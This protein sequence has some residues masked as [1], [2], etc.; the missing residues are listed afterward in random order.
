M[1]QTPEGEEAPG[2]AQ[3][4]VSLR[5]ATEASARLCA[6][7]WLPVPFVG[8]LLCKATLYLNRRG[9]GHGSF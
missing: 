1:E 3:D 4:V 6:M 5:S 8:A 2:A 9:I 7:A